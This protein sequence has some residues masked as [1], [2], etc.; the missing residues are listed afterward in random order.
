MNLGFR[1]TMHSSSKIRSALYYLLKP[2]GYFLVI[3]GIFGPILKKIWPEIVS[4]LAY[5][6]FFFSNTE[7]L[8][9]SG[10]SVNK[11]SKWIGPPK[12]WGA[13]GSL[14][15]A[16]RDLVFEDLKNV[17]P[18]AFE[19]SHRVTL[20]KFCPNLFSRNKGTLLAVERSGEF[21]RDSSVSF[22]IDFNN[23][24]EA[25]GISGK[26]FC[27]SGQIKAFN[28]PD[29]TS[30]LDSNTVGE[31][32]SLYAKRTNVARDWILKERPKSRSIVGL[33]IEISEKY[34][35]VIVIDSRN[36]EIPDKYLSSF[37]I[38]AISIGKLLQEL[39]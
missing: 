39:K 7:I 35:G 26:A 20:F 29:I 2:I 27:S 17:D 30:E 33:R 18:T 5:L 15:T 36:E 34:W 25:E 28:L 12:I 3:S 24:D 19:Y 21:H 13:V 6:R 11:F 37:D 31:S 10:L 4:G 16:Y 22:K 23:P 14:L 1:N 38:L 32:I 9:L 8:V